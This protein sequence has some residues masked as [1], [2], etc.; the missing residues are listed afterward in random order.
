MESVTLPKTD[1]LNIPDV[2][3]RAQLYKEIRDGAVSWDRWEVSID[4]QLR[5]DLVSL[6][7]Y[8]TANFKSIVAV[9]AGLD[10]WRGSLQAGSLIAL[11][12]ARWIR[13]RI[14]H[15]LDIS[16]VDGAP[17]LRQSVAVAIKK[18]EPVKA[19]RI[20]LYPPKTPGG[21]P[22]LTLLLGTNNG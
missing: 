14:R 21:L 16:T 13:Q 2:L 5:P 10:D 18:P 9:A 11:P 12:P 22:S 7:Y 20:A 19:Q 17:V 6:R 15:Y 4:E 8:G 3:Y 1:P